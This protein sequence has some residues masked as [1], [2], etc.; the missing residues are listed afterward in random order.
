M[1]LQ[2]F[3]NLYESD[4]IPS[5]S[6]C[7]WRE[8]GCLAPGDLCSHFAV[9]R[10]TRWFMQAYCNHWRCTYFF[11][12][13]TRKFCF[14]SSVSEALLRKIYLSTWSPLHLSV[15]SLLSFWISILQFAH[16]LGTTCLGA[17]STSYSGVKLY[18][19][20]FCLIMWKAVDVDNITLHSQPWHSSGTIACVFLCERSDNKKYQVQK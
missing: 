15:C 17:S 10:A 5:K 12:L 2:T 11:F 7:N 16:H 13:L 6:D 3:A 14:Y 8:T 18:S 9:K 1:C 19:Y 20:I 4:C